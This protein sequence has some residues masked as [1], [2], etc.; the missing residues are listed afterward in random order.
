MVLNVMISRLAKRYDVWVRFAPPARLARQVINSFKA[1][2]VSAR[3]R[4]VREPGSL[5]KSEAC[6]FVCY[7][8]NNTIPAHALFHARAWASA[9]FR[10]ILIVALDEPDAF[11]VGDDLDFADAILLR[12]N[13]GYDFGAWATAIRLLPQVREARIVA[14]VNDSVYGPFEG[15]PEMIARARAS[16]A[17]VIGLTESFELRRH[18]QSYA[19]FFKDN[20]L[21]SVA[22]NRFW[23]SV[24][25]GSRRHVID[26]YELLLLTRMEEAGLACETLFTGPKDG[27]NPTLT[28][29]RELLEQGFPFIK[30][31]LLRDNP[32]KADLSNWRQVIGDHGSQLRL[33]EDHLAQNKRSA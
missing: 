24:R 4:W 12:Q 3:H 14:I 2:P 15:F 27:R 32:G 20:A 22:F 1:D 30:V 9:G 23:R 8:P 33:I 28:I 10:V 25:V 11:R 31:Q 7:A 21:T 26:N 16:H 29:W 5:A 6:V 19:L 18:F 17:D 13:A